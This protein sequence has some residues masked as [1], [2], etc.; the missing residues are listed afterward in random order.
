MT[1]PVRW[2]ILGAAKFAR[3]HMGPAIHAARGAELAGLATGSPDKAAAFQDFAP[4]LQVYDDYDALLAD[5]GIDAVYVPL[6]NHLHV[7]WTLKA[8][9]AGKAVLCEKPIALQA[10]EIDTIIAARDKAGVL[11]AEAF[12]IVHHPQW[13]LV[14]DWIAEGKIGDLVHVRGAFSFDNAADVTNIRN[15]TETGGGAL[16]DIGV[17]VLGSVRFATGQ[18]PVEIGAKIRW[19][20]GIDGFA[21]IDAT[22]PG[23]T[24]ASY[25][26]M[27]MAPYQEMSF[28]GTKGT[29]R[30]TTPFNAGVFGEARVELHHP[31]LVV[32]TRRFPRVNHYVLQVENFGQSL[33]VGTPYGCPLEFTRGTQAALDRIYAG[34][35]SL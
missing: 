31:D 1:D 4:R 29:I 3:E 24:Y 32:E 15:R 5:P 28:H 16:R 10:A 22:F 21:A 35:E 27:R 20:N 33:R 19:D 9:A 17:Y 13:Q 7:D 6:P 2:G 30:L 18:E 14:R 23:F 8:I 11:A 34:A 12:M 25:V 26:S